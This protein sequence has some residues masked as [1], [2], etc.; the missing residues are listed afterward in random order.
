M[1]EKAVLC[2]PPGRGWAVTLGFAGELVLLG[3]A[4]AVP[5]IWP[6][7]LSRHEVMSWLTAPSPPPPVIRET[8]VPHVRPVRRPLREGTI[9]LPIH[10]M[11]QPAVMFDEPPASI[12][13]VT[14]GSGSSAPGSVFPS[15]LDSTIRI[16]PPKRTTEPTA[17]TVPKP[18]TAPVQ[19]IRVSGPIQAA[20]LIHRVDP[21]YPA[22]ARQMRVSGTVELAG[23]IA[24]NGQIREL[25]VTSGH[26]LLAP[27]ALAAV[28][29]W[30]YQ[31]TLLGGNP[32][33]VITTI[34]VVFRIN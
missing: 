8:T 13:A 17:A 11:F 24:A 14:G 33:E 4:L 29:E 34:S 16:E 23:V 1:F 3:C 30:V 6:Q 18:A 20:R 12:P 10:T 26:P 7:V 2:P 22:L 5:L 9:W 15:I 31:P 25:R 32:V 19:Q 27:A 28:R 21:M